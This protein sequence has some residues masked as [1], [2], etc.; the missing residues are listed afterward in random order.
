VWHHLNRLL[1]VTKAGLLRARGVR[2]LA[3]GVRC[4][5]VHAQPGCAPIWIV[6][7]VGPETE[8]GYAAMTTRPI[9]A[10]SR[11]NRTERARGYAAD[12][13]PPSRASRRPALGGIAAE[14]TRLGIPVAA[15]SSEC[16]PAQVAW[17]LHQ[18]RWRR[19][20]ELIE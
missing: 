17:V 19:A 3:T 16:R 11:R 15:G 13:A 5:R 7:P 6:L 1:A 4:L 8:W 9:Q 20:D 18:L 14:L 2:S 10:F 12:L